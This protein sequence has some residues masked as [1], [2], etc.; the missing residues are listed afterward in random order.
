M[1]TVP[2]SAGG[3]G[4][5]SAAAALT[6]IGAQ[7]AMTGVSSDGAN[8]LAVAGAVAAGTV[9]A[10]V[11]GTLF[12]NASP[13]GAVCNGVAT[14][15]DGPAIRAA[16]AVAKTTHQSVQLPPG[17]CV[18]DA[19]ITIDGNSVSAPPNQSGVRVYGAG[20]SATFLYFP[21]VTSGAAINITQFGGNGLH[22]HDLSIIG[23]GT[24]AGTPDGIYN[25]WSNNLAIDHVAVTGFY[26]GIHLYGCGAT[27][28]ID[29]ISSTYNLNDGI[30]LDATS[31]ASVTNSFLAYNGGDDIYLHS[32]DHALLS[33]NTIG[34]V[35][36]T[37]VASSYQ[38]N[39]GIHV[40]GATGTTAVANRIEGD[41]FVGSLSNPVYSWTVSGA[42]WSGGV[43]TYTTSATIYFAT[44]DLISISGASPS[45]YNIAAY[46]NGA[47]CVATVTGPT[48][49]TCPVASNPGTFSSSGTVTLIAGS[50]GVLDSSGNDLYLGNYFSHADVRPASASSFFTRLDSYPSSVTPAGSGSYINGGAN[51]TPQSIVTAYDSSTGQS[52]SVSMGVTANTM[53]AAFVGSLN[54]IPF[55]IKQNGIAVATATASLF[56]VNYGLT[57][58]GSTILNGSVTANSTV[59]F[60]NG[61]T[62]LSNMLVATGLAFRSTTTNSTDITYT[63]FPNHTWQDPSNSYWQ[64][65]KLSAGTYPQLQ[66]IDPSG[67]VAKLQSVG[68]NGA[69]V[70]SQNAVP[71]YLISNNTRG[72]G[73]DAS[74]NVG[75]GTT[76][77]TSDKIYWDVSGLEHNSIG[78]AIASATTIAPLAKITHITGTT[79]IATITA[80]TGCT[81]SGW[82]CQLTLIPDGL[83]TTTTAGNIAIASTAVVSKAEIMTYDPATAKWYPSY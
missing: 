3:T 55:S 72:L 51:S 22:L 26:N 52:P 60:Q 56:T 67:N 80:P 46:A 25:L 2:I 20:Q 74:G 77:P 81:T 7:P 29:T 76:T 71:A 1:S 30:F 54:N 70:G 79:A 75:V 63:A 65:A 5:S 59:S 44:G 13:F 21:S 43:A 12:A 23:P 68:S 24:G 28:L 83:W 45:G 27:C 35:S 38:G 58:T 33:N 41:V 53:D 66:V 31:D 8:G 18:M 82:S 73:L 32:G 47:N 14:G 40:V 9:A 34:V 4:A 19:G 17:V 48:T 15:V 57:V 50:H 36:G 64:Y 6:S 11:N 69:Y 10:S 61:F 62:S 49:F 42:T 78:A 16:L 39:Y 37:A